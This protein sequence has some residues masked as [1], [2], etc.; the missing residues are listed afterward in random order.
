M[1]R[2]TSRRAIG[3]IFAYAQTPPLASASYLRDERALCGVR[4]V[5]RILR[6]SAA[7]HRLLAH[8]R[9]IA[10]Q[11]HEAHRGTQDS[12]TQKLFFF[13]FRRSALR[14]IMDGIIA[15]RFASRTARRRQWRDGIESGRIARPGSDMVISIW[16]QQYHGAK[17]GRK[18][19]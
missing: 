14:I 4:C 11:R 6:A 13:F 2:Q 19:R 7:R 16:H 8:A 12:Q 9:G 3:R 5:A 10:V 17:N 15:L 1:P 18:H